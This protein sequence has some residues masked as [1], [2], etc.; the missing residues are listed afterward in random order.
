MFSHAEKNHKNS[1]FQNKNLWK[2]E[3]N[4]S[5]HAYSERLCNILW[6]GNWGENKGNAP[7]LWLRSITHDALCLLIKIRIRDHWKTAGNWSFFCSTLLIRTA[8][9]IYLSSFENHYNNECEKN[10]MNDAMKFERAKA[11]V[12][13]MYENGWNFDK[14]RTQR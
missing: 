5:L 10:K 8:T 13:D 1:D 9:V 4:L 14:N 3:I 7:K 6:T 11:D 2:M 12:G